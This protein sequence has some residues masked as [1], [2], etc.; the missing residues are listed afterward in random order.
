MAAQTYVFV[1]NRFPVLEA[2]LERGLQIA[3]IFALQDSYL[4]KELRARG[5]D[6]A[7]L[8]SKEALCASL[9]GLGFDRLVSNGC[10]YILPV[11]SLKKPHQLFVN[12][13]P[14]PLPDL[15]GMH[16][17]NAAILFNRPA[18]ATCHAMDDGV[19]TGPLITRKEI[20]LDDEMTLAR[21]FPLLFA[22]EREVFLEAL[23]RDFA[24]AELPPLVRESLIYYTRKDA[25]MAIDFAA[26]PETIIRQVRAFSV[27]T[28]G[29]HFDWRGKRFRVLEAVILHESRAKNYAEGEIVRREGDAVIVRRGDSLLR[30]GGIVGEVELL[31]P[32]QQLF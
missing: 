10:P 3:R 18:G 5:M 9:A 28:Q 29:A 21:L 31:T 24:P 16:P 7:A 19:D 11:S 30:L 17:A 2:M 14:A 27:E 6:Y 8:E 12:V 26:A 1:G 25:D 22:A 15:R 4:E 32:G 23:A 13:H 20:P